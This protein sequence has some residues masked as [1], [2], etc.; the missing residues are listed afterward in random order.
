[1][2]PVEREHAGGVGLDR[3]ME[4]EAAAGIGCGHGARTVVA[5]PLAVNPEAG[6]RPCAGLTSTAGAGTLARP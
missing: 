5:A 2:G 4:V 1:V 3:G 6:R